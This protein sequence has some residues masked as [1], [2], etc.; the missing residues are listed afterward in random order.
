MSWLEKLMPS[1]IDVAGERKKN[2]PEGIW[3]KCDQCQAVLYR[4]ELERTL[5]V[6]PKCSAHRP[7]PARLRLDQFLDPEPREEIGADIEATDPLKFRDTQKYKDRL[8]AAQRK[9]GEKDALVAIRGELLKLPVVTAAFE[10]RFI[11]GS[12][13]SAVGEK[14]VRAVN[15]A[16]EQGTPFILSL[17][18]I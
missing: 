17:I 8:T 12:M 7:I 6:C 18:H 4:A 16:I 3:T 13:G 15:V 14:F 2:V 10:F 5:E 9:T 1:R 11:G